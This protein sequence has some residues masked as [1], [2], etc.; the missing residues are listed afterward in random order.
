MELGKA[1][2]IG[3]SIRDLFDSRALHSVVHNETHVTSV[4]HNIY[5]LLRSLPIGGTEIVYRLLMGAVFHSLIAPH[6]LVLT[7]KIFHI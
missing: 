2:A 7:R 1:P 3:Q 6:Y 5:T 4:G